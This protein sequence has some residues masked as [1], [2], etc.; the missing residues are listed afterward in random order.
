MH[1]PAEVCPP[2]GLLRG[3]SVSVYIGGDVLMNVLYASSSPHE[4]THHEVLIHNYRFMV[5]RS[6]CN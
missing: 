5:Y 2:K 4:V 1:I 6:S 3:Y